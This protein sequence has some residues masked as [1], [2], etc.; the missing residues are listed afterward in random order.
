[1]SLIQNGEGEYESVLLHIRAVCATIS[2]RE[3]IKYLFKN[4]DVGVIPDAGLPE[5]ILRDHL[6]I[7]RAGTSIFELISVVEPELAGNLLSQIQKERN[8]VEREI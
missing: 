1:M 2:G 5:N 7:M 3:F 6:G 8:H 4:L